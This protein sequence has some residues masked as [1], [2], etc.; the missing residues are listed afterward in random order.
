MKGVKVVILTLLITVSAIVILYTDVEYCAATL[1]RFKSYE[2]L[3]EFLQCREYSFEPFRFLSVESY[4]S[5]ELKAMWGGLND[6]SKTNVQVE[7]VDE[8]DIVKTDGEYI[9]VISGQKVVIVKAYPA[10][11][12]AVLSKIAVNGTLKEIFINEERLIVFYESGSLSEIKTFINTYDISDRENPISKG[13]IAVDGCYFTSRMIGDYVYVVVRKSA[14]LVEGEVALPEIY[15]ESEYKVI[16]ATEIYYSDIADYGYIFTTIVAVNVQE[17]GQEPTDETILSGWTTNMYVSLENIYL[18]IGYRDKTILHRIHI[19][20]GEI[21]YG[22]D[23]EVPGTVLNQFSMDEH[24]GYFRIATTSP[25]T[26]SP[27]ESAWKLPRQNNVYVLNMDLEIVGKLEN[28]APGETIH[29]ARFMGNTCYLVT[30]EKIDPF[31]VINLSDPYSP[32]ILGELKITGYSDYLHLYDENHVIGVGKETISAEAGDFSWYQG[33]KIS[34][35]DVTDITEP[36]ELA[37]YEIGNRGTDSPVLRDHKAFLFD[38]EKNLLVIPVSVAEIDESK[39]PNGV[40]PYISGEIVWQ[41]AYVFTISLTLEEKIM[42]RGTITHVENGDVHNISYHIKRTLYIGEVL[43]TI[44]NNKI[45]MNS[46]PDL[47]EINELNL[48]E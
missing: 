3:K 8:A 6:Y 46:L 16:P 39:Y 38:K 12:A 31:F 2:E 32:E 17:D 1:N 42:L 15:S 5:A 14:S 20:N 22:A 40:P 10:E 9:Y 28:I 21:S 33:V 7:G 36:K 26:S 41:G 4:G 43:Y 30:F 18:A 37:K 45:K 27:E 24:E 44:S 47:S 25:I 34:L 11:E 35:F 23:G 29:S 13:E 48:N 19:E